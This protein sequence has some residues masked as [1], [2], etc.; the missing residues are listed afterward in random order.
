MRDFKLF[1][2]AALRKTGFELRRYTIQTSADAQLMRTLSHFDVD[3]VL[4]IGANAGQYGSAL[5]EHGYR[6]R[7]VSFEPS[8]TAHA[9]LV[10]HASGDPNWTVA[11]RMALGASSGTAVLNLAGNSV[12][13]S[14][15]G[16]LPSHEAAAPDS[17]YFGT[18][19]VAIQTL[20]SLVP[21]YLKGARRILL[22]IDTQG[23][24]DAVLA[25]AEACLHLTLAVQIELSMIPLYKDQMLFDE[26]RARLDALGFELYALYPVYSD[27]RTGRTLQM[28][29]LFVRR[30]L[31]RP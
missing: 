12:S 1:V 19:E 30:N 21:E 26:T 15:R 6:N 23:F 18:E 16:M 2:K 14:L 27:E 25:G 22:K 4:D 5:R 13:N 11:P 29:G 17:A 28:D 9:E 24:E 10:R 31:A 20:D 3:L 8:S 7:I